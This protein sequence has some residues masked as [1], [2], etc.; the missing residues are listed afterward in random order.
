MRFV[1]STYPRGPTRDPPVGSPLRPLRKQLRFDRTQAR[2]RSVGVDVID[3]E[4]SEAIGVVQV[5]LVT[6]SGKHHEATAF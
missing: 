2:V 6:R 3:D 1:R 4:L 5:R